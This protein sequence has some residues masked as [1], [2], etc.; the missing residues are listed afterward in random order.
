MIFQGIWT[1]IAKKPYKEGGS[2]PPVPP[3]DPRITWLTD[4]TVAISGTRHCFGKCYNIGITHVFS[5]IKF[6]R[7]LRK[8]F[9][10]EA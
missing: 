9:E 5:C 1:S 10:H 2:G 4:T 3:L 7:V 8:L 6:C